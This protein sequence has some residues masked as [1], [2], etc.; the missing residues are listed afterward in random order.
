MK[1]YWHIGFFIIVVLTFFI[2][3]AH[4]HNIDAFRGWIASGC[5][6]ILLWQ[7]CHEYDKLKIRALDLIDALKGEEK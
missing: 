6:E 2:A 3:I 4:Y 7:K 1:W 5:A